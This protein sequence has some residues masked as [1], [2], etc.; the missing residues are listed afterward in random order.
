MGKKN[1]NKNNGL[2]RPLPSRPR[3]Q[4]KV[5]ELRV[6]PKARCP[7]LA[8]PCQ[9]YMRH[10][11][12]NITLKAKVNMSDKNTNLMLE[13]E[14]KVATNMLESKTNLYLT[15]RAINVT[16][17]TQLTIETVKSLNI[18]KKKKNQMFQVHSQAANVSRRMPGMLS[19]A[20]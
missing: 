1:K 8:G 10:A 4:A 19:I 13:H 20:C 3:H 12:Q 7:L 17:I 16:T 9:S 15:T 11:P 14:L 18:G 2:A 6:V 5:P